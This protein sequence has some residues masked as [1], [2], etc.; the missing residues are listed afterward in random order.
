MQRVGTRIGGCFFTS[1]CLLEDDRKAADLSPDSS[2][3]EAS[4]L[5]RNPPLNGKQAG[6]PGQGGCAEAANEVV[7][8]V[9]FVFNK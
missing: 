7:T 1:R 6:R 4:K 5:D 2:S 9:F 8:R 3:L